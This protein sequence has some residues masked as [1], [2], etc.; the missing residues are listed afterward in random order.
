[1]VLTLTAPSFAIEDITKEP[2]TMRH[3]QR[4]YEL[5]QHWFTITEYTELRYKF[6]Q[7]KPAIING[8]WNLAYA[9]AYRAIKNWEDS[10]LAAHR[11]QSA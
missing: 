3:D 8:R 10:Y 7:I 2:K 9:N 4:S 11:E 6:S 1:M 5:L